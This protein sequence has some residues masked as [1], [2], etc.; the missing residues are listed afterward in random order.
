MTSQA[1]RQ[2]STRCD[3]KNKSMRMIRISFFNQSFTLPA[4]ADVGSMK[5]DMKD[6]RFTVM[7]RKKPHSPRHF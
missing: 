5:T 1:Q 7:H 6:G 3:G 4:D 2:E